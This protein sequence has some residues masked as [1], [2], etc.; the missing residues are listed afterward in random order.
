MN[1]KKLA[2]LSALALT[3]VLGLMFF[4][5]ERTRAAGTWYVNSTTGSNSF[6]CMSPATACQTINAAIGKASSGDTIN[7]AA[8]LYSESVAINKTLTL[9]GAQA[10]VDAR[11][12]TGAESII[13]NACSPVSIYADNVTLNGFTVQGSTTADPCNIAGIWTNPGYSGT[14]GGHQILYNIIQNNIAGIELDNSGVFQTKVQYNLIQNNNNDGPGPGNGI[15]VTTFGLKNAL[16][17]KN[18]FSGHVNSSMIVELSSDGIAFSNNELVG[19]ATERV[20]FGLVTN[21]SITGN[22]SIGSTSSGT[23]RLF[24]GNNGITITCNTLASGQRGIRVDDCCELGPNSNITANQNNIQGNAIAGLEVAS[25]SYFGGSLDATQNW[26]GSPSGPFNATS[27]PSGT[28]NAVVDPDGAVTFIP[29]RTSPSSCAPVPDLCPLDPNKT[30]PGVCGCGT[31]D[32]DTDHDGTPDCNDACP[33]DPNKTAAGA[34]GCGHVDTPGCTTN[35]KD[36]HQFVENEEKNFNDGQKNQKK[37]F[38]DQQKTD[39]KNFDATHPTP[40]Q[41]KAFEEGQ[42]NDKKNFDDQQKAAKDAFQVHY[43]AE[44]QQCNQLPK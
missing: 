38:D 16:I 40:A 36:C 7:V 11:T 42:K 4:G 21:S 34:C 1:S 3:L 30:D 20:V 35:K 39:K 22:T 33:S 24:G 29:Y 44:E 13:D 2:V 9:L 8:G 6:D 32:T 31:P 28:G 25:G 5:G 10:N 19:G 26:W 27:N 12:R 41:R 14:Q 18:K 17:D 43:K 23:I 15:E 37:A